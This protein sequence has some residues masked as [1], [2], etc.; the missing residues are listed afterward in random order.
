MS[1]TLPRYLIQSL[2]CV[3]ILGCATT[4]VG[5]ALPNGG[6]VIGLLYAPPTAKPGWKIYGLPDDPDPYVFH[7]DPSYDNNPARPADIPGTYVAFTAFAYVPENGPYDS[8]LMTNNG[9][10]LNPVWGYVDTID[11]FSANTLVLIHND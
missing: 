10:V 3:V 9:T 2:V 5:T 11:L 6:E 7:R 1:P 8:D 4:G